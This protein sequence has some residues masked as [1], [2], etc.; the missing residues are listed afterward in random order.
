MLVRAIKSQRQI[1]ETCGYDNVR[2]LRGRIQDLGLDLDLLD[3]YLAEHPVNSSADW[4][5]LEEHTQHLRENR[6]N[7]FNMPGAVLSWSHAGGALVNA[8][9]PT[10][11]V[12]THDPK[13]DLLA[14]GH[15]AVW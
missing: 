11:R 4:M 2:F 1:S 10:K 15:E 12:H 5:A 9:G 14:D 13:F 8:N 3:R 7:A 6:I